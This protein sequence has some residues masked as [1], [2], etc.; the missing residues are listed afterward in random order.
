MKILTELINRLGSKLDSKLKS[1]IH[2]GYI[3][4]NI[5]SGNVICAASRL[6]PWMVSLRELLLASLK[7]ARVCLEF[8]KIKNLNCNKGR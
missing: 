4:K 8:L 5:K 7:Q 6:Q 1:F 2:V 3:Y